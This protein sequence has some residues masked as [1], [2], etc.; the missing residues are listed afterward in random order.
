MPFIFCG[1]LN[2]IAQSMPKTMVNKKIGSFW[3]F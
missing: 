1:A 2:A 3:L